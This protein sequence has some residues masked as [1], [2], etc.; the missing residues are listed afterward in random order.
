MNQH[1]EFAGHTNASIRKL[2]QN[3]LQFARKQKH[4]DSV[5]LQEV[6]ECTEVYQARKEPPAKIVR[7]EK[8]VEYFS[9]RVEELGINVVV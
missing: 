5:S 4:T 3:C 1:K 8:I 9:Q 6:A 7:R 2:F